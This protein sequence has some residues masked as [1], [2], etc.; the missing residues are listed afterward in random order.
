MDV[1]A[2]LNVKATFDV[3]AIAKRRRASCCIA[4]MIESEEKEEVGK[5]KKEPTKKRKEHRRGAGRQ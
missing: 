3:R 4:D 1:M 2:L 5:I